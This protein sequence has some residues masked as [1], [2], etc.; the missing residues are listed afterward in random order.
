[1][2]LAERW[3]VYKS[4]STLMQARLAIEAVATYAAEQKM[5]KMKVI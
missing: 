5:K 2:D 3:V 1:M 4:S